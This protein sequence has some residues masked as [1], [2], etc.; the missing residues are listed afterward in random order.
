M[1]NRAVRRRA[2]A[3]IAT[4]LVATLASGLPLAAAAQVA[5]P[6]ATAP[7]A[8]APPSTAP[9]NTAP[10]STAPPNTALPGTAAADTAPPATGEA[11]PTGAAAVPIDPA[12]AFA[13]V[14]IRP[15]T[16][17][18][19]TTG[20]ASI[21]MQP[22]GRFLATQITVR[23]LIK[24]AYG[25]PVLEDARLVGGPSWTATDRYDIDAR[26]AAG[27]AAQEMQPLLRTLLATHFGLVLRRD[28]R[29]SLVYA[30]VLAAADGRLGPRLRRSE[31]CTTSGSRQG[32]G[33][34][35]DPASMCGGGG[36]AGRLAFG[37]IP[38]AIG[39]VPAL[40]SEVQRPV[41]DR[42]GLTGYFDAS[43]EWTPNQPAQ[44]PGDGPAAPADARSIFTALQ[45]QLG[46]KL[47]PATARVEALVIDA[48]DRP[49]AN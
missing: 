41:I 22:G 30:L 44:P 19:G 42:T 45:E 46:L 35:A 32:A 17:D 49:A 36:S 37:G 34:T 14:S 20:R 28:A 5:A 21:G 25:S 6:P 3:I 26:A 2:P 43:L 1:E 15:A 38:L 7:P 39:L 8:T 40:T 9:P 10:P 11:P 23:D 31:D 16:R 33:A 29:E 13:V 48:V 47:V 12:E 4:A 18:P 24:L 27:A